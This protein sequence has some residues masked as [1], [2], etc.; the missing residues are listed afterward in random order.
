MLGGHDEQLI[1]R[2]REKSTRTKTPVLAIIFKVSIPS[3][4]PYLNPLSHLNR[5]V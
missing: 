2:L 3:L 5:D 1:K 4:S